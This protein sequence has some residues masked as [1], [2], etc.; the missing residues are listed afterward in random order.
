[1]KI[2]DMLKIKG[3]TTFIKDIEEKDMC[4][5]ERTCDRWLSKDIVNEMIESG[6]AT[7]IPRVEERK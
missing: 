6:E 1:M 5:K 7:L 4:V 3:E 2:G